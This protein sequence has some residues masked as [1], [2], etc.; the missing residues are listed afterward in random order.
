MIH[1]PSDDDDDDAEPID[2]D[3]SDLGIT[4]G[5]NVQEGQF[6]KDPKD[7]QGLNGNHEEPNGRPS[8]D[9]TATAGTDYTTMTEGST[10]SV[11]PVQKRDSGFEQKAGKRSEERKHRGLSQWTP[12]RNVRFAKDEAK[13]GMSKLKKRL[14][15]GGLGGR[16]PGVETET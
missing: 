5:T 16:E 9:T 13:I 4:D 15:M 7:V 11:Q 1:S 2:D 10:N 3:S 8:A 6:R 14:G 12:A